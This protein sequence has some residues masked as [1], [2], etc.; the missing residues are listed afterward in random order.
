[1]DGIPEE[2]NLRLSSRI[3]MHVRE[4]TQF[5]NKTKLKT[6]LEGERTKLKVYNTPSSGWTETFY[7]PTTF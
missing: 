3:H 2:Q 5:K 4:Q 6:E 1:M 7:P